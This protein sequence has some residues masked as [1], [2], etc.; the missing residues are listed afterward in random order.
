MKESR[1]NKYDI[2]LF[3]L[4]L[5][6]AGG[7]WGG[8]F[9]PARVMSIVFFIPVLIS[10]TKV[11]IRMIKE[12]TTFLFFLLIWGFASLLWTPNS[13]LGV[14]EWGNMVL[15]IIFFLELIVF[16]ALSKNSINTL[17]NGWSAAFLITAIIAIWELTTGNHLEVTNY[18]EGAENINLGGGNVIARQYAQATFYNYNGYVTFLCY[19]LPFLF[20]LAMMWS[21]GL[22]LLLAAIPL[23]LIV[24]VFV[25][26]ASRGGILGLIIYAAVFSYFKLSKSKFSAKLSFLIL[27]AIVVCIFAYFWDLI[28]F[29]LEMRME[30]GGMHSS[31]TQI[32]ACCWQALLDTGF[33]GCGVGGVMEA[34]TAQHAYIPQPH[35]FFIE[36]ALEFGIFVFIWMIVLM[37]KVFR[38]GRNCKDNVVRFIRISSLFAIPFIT[39]I[40][41][42]YLQSI[43][44]WAFLGS[45]LIINMG[46]NRLNVKI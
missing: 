34:L 44:L 33:I 35:D 8:A 46:C 9:K 12:V 36:V 14:S 26:N 10:Y 11:K 27:F 23:V 2:L 31:R 5:C 21:R 20:S 43:D 13:G 29:Y 41:S 15:R 42:T 28:S 19:C 45:L 32:W 16:G 7:M 6:T 18:V 24:Y 37:W 25:L 22:K 40:D 30:S 38:M 17:I 4:I 3:V 39:M 1:F